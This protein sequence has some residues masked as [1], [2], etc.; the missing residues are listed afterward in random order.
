VN[1]EKIEEELTKVSSPYIISYDKAESDK[2]WNFSLQGRKVW[3][4]SLDFTRFPDRLPYVKL[5][6]QTDVGTLAHVNRKCTVCVEESDTILIDINRFPEVIETFLSSIVELLDYSSHK[7]AQDELTDEYE[8]YFDCDKKGSVNSFYTATGTLE[9]ASLK[10]VLQKAGQNYKQNKPHNPVLLLNHHNVYPKNFSNVQKVTSTIINIIHLPLDMPVLPPVDAQNISDGNKKVLNKLL[11]KTKSK[12]EFFILLSIPRRDLERTQLLL[13]FTSK[14]KLDHPLLEYSD[15]WEIGHYSIQRHNKEY[16][17][18]RGGA[19][20]SLS[21][22]KVVIVGCGSV[23]SEIA[24]MLAKSGVGTLTLI[25]KDTLEADNIYRHRLGGDYLNYVPNKAANVDSYSKVVSLKLAIE[26]DLPY[27]DV[28]PIS[29]F[30]ENI[31]DKD[32]IQNADLVIFAVGSP[33]LNL[34]FNAELKK[35]GIKNAVFCW[36]EAAG[37]GGHSVFLN[38]TESCLECLYTEEEGYSNI[39]KLN[40]LESGQNISKNL[41]G[42]AG[43]FTPFSYLDS[44]QTAL[45]ATTQAV[46][47]LLD[48]NSASKAISW[49]GKGNGALSTTERYDIV[50]LM[51]EVGINK[52][53]YCR[54]CNGE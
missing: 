10:I 27:V 46:E 24:F 30:F 11:Q 14:Y 49:K 5:L 6:E 23:G 45:L 21:D 54:V 13:H 26:K 7:I 4:V 18:E 15:K 51:E 9:F 35:R 3:N 25:D 42:C 19:Q 37:Y 40:F 39:C 38:S 17:L 33:A 29:T 22:K 28:K 52:E 36:N 41:T 47:F 8:G 48:Q 43:V 32:Y 1:S 44:S 16:L 53:D 31:I 12:K 34:K 50:S 2:A 20:N